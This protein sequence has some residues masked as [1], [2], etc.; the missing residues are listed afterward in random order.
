MNAKVKT[1]DVIYAD[2]P[3]HFKVW[4]KKGAGRSAE[5]HYPTQ[6]P[7]FLKE[8][9]IQ[10]IAKPDCVLLMWTTFPCL[11]QALEL[12]KAWGFTYKTVAFTWIKTNKNND[13]I[14]TGM[15]YYTRANAEI[16]LLFTKGKP[17]VRHAKDVPQVLVSPRSRHSE[18]PDEI[19]K[20][21]VRLFGEVDRVE[22]FARQSPAEDN[23]NTF[24]GWDV[25]G[26]EVDNSIEIP[27]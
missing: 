2:P 27:G 26:N 21:I 23:N 11:E 17:L 6:S 24:E 5:S 22:L 15:G 25:F 1:Y 16:V 13:R 8:M 10:A 14:F 9:N 12:G 19:R 20:R 4:S 3:W 7:E 18:K